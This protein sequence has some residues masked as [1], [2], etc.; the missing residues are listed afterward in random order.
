M[1]SF[2]ISLPFLLA[3]AMPL[4]AGQPALRAQA[5]APALR[6]FIITDFGAVAGGKVL[7]SAAI[8]SA[9]DQAGAAGGGVVEI[10]PGTFRSGS[11]FLKPGV[12]LYLDEG[13]VLLGSNQIEDY[14]KRI[15]RIEGHFEPWRMALVNAQQMDRVRIGGKGMLNGNGF[16]F[17]AAFWQRRSENPACTNLEVE[18]PRLM[19]I[20]RCHDVRIGGLALKNSGFWNLHLYRCHDVV[21]DGLSISAPTKGPILGPSTD[22]M[23][24]DSC[25]DVAIRRCHIAV[26]D[27][28]I[29][30][31]G[32]KGPL[33]DHDA[34]SPP[35]ENILI[36]DCEFGD[37]NGM[38]TCGSE[39][40][41][42]RHV[43]VRN[44]KITGKTNLICL[45]LRPDTPQDYENITID[46]IELSGG[47]G[48]LVQV[49]PW[50]QFFDLAGH[51]PPTQRISHVTLR[52]IT[53]TFGSFGGLRGNPGDTLS[54]ITLENIDVTLADPKL[55]LGKTENLVFDNVRVN[56]ADYP[57]PPATP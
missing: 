33:A 35:V 55:R 50:M 56:G 17:W 39:A 37:G 2:R 10:P 23:D 42:I 26:N 54:D 21:V 36:E 44:C 41:V 29:A 9:I 24:I 11:I 5:P 6:H 47:T 27:D 45:K 12:E 7:N 46:G 48:R 8:Q 32:S 13:A 34:D 18:R 53:G 14:P 31:K 28:N 57:V 16:L 15:T 4:L 43:T 22:G 49:A 3:S 20:D 38:L 1:T 30:L 19:F 25:Q 51:A 52:N 40:T